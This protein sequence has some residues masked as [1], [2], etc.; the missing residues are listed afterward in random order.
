MRLRSCPR[1]KEVK[2]LVERGQWPVAAATDP[3]L[4]AHV[5]GCRFCSELAL[6]SMAFQKA[7]AEAAE[8]AKLGPPGVLWWRAQQRQRNAALERIG[9]PILGAQIFALAVNLLVAVDFVA[10]QARHGLAWLTRVEQLSHTAAFHLDSQ[11]V[12]SL[13]NAAVSGSTWNWMILLPAAATLA[14]LGGAAV[15]LAFEKR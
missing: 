10:W 11:W 9:R 14:L 8:V 7:R 13:W 15:Y 3:D 1:E 2:E 5:S 4:R 6:V 12:Y